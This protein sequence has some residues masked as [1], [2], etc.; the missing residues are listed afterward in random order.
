MRACFLSF[1]V[2]L[3]CT[4][5]G[6]RLLAQS[7]TIAGRIVQGTKPV[8]GVEIR[9]GGSAYHTYSDTTGYFCFPRVRSDIYNLRV[10][11]QGAS[12]RHATVDVR[13]SDVTDL[14][15]LIRLDACDPSAAQ[16]DIDAAS[17]RL[18]FSVGYEGAFR[19]S[20]DDK[21]FEQRYGVKYN[22]YGCTGPRERCLAA[23]NQVIIN[24]LD[25][26]FG[27]TWREDVHADFRDRYLK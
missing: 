17:P 1:I 15:I 13:E 18:L 20:P 10:M 4:T 21:A 12:P 14:K 22:V 3:I 6:N 26:K 25:D 11:H 9:V 24:Y 2:I 23:Y 19:M 27:H 5:A 16:L 8:P 7:R